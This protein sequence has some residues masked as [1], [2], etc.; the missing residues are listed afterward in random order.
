MRELGWAPCGGLGAFFGLS[1][2]PAGMGSRRCSAQRLSAWWA[3]S[4]SGACRAAVA[5]VVLLLQRYCCTSGNYPVGLRVLSARVLEALTVGTSASSNS[6]WACHKNQQNMSLPQL[7]INGV[8]DSIKRPLLPFVPLTNGPGAA[9][10]AAVKAEGRFPGRHVLN[11]SG[12]ARR[13]VPGRSFLRRQ[14]MG[15]LL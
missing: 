4:S 12:G 11:V 1:S 9:A 7:C 8:I 14:N 13:A 5:L 3:V 2:T 6:A 10:G 15:L